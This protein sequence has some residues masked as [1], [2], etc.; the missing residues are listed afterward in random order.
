MNTKSPNVSHINADGGDLETEELL[1]I[2]R[3]LGEQ[4]DNLEEV[5]DAAKEHRDDINGGRRDLPVWVKV[6]MQGLFKPLSKDF[7]TSND[8]FQ[9]ERGTIEAVRALVRA[10]QNMVD[11]G[12]CVGG[13]TAL[14]AR[15]VGPTGRVLA[16]EANPRLA[17]L[18]ARSV[19]E[20]LAVKVENK[21]VGD[22][23]R[24]IPVT[25]V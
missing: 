22:G 19:E 16:V 12:A 18:L 2:V 6:E 5:P 23:D 4:I 25:L 15:A 9:L 20:S 8:N 1:T 10:G 21:A 13:Y 7:A 17:G 11:V 3:D 24:K 14:F